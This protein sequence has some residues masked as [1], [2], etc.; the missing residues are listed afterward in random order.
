[1]NNREQ[2]SP[3]PANAARVEKNDGDTWALIL[4]KQLKHSPEMVWAALTDPDQLSQWAPFDADAN[5]GHTGAQVKLATVGAP[6]EHIESTT[7]TRAEPNRLLEYRWGGGEIRWELERDEAGTRLTLWANINRKYVAMG[8]AG[9]H[10]CLDVLQHLL[11]G[12]PLGRIVGPDALKFGGWQKL[13]QGYSD[14]F[15]VE[16]VSW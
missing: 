4:V 15:G 16:P 1:M 14:Q 8:A 13:N 2:Y 5:L 3:G 11:D 12:D 7:I 6:K 10:L 9:W